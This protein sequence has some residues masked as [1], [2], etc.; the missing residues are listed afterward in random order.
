[1]V[2]TYI[3]KY[4][5]Q[6]GP[7]VLW[8]ILDIATLNAYT[9]FRGQHPQIKSSVTSARCVFVNEFSQ[10]LFTSHMRSWLECCCN[11]K[12]NHWSNGKVYDDKCHNSA[13]GKKKSR[14]VDQRDGSVRCVRAI[15]NLWEKYMCAVIRA[16]NRSSNLVICQTIYSEETRKENIEEL[17]GQLHKHE[18]TLLCC[19]FYVKKKL[20]KNWKYFKHSMCYGLGECQCFSTELAVPVFLL[21]A[22]N[23][24]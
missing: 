17:S 19:K 8:Y 12:P 15:H 18:H 9:F 3:R 5:T 11:C 20:K 13:T 7:M 2:G 10:E 22:L 4:Q 1:M 16:R 14:R 6:S 21:I 23:Y 24:G